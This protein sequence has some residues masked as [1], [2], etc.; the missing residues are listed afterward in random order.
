MM[1]C[2]LVSIHVH[3]CRPLLKLSLSADDEVNKFAS[4]EYQKCFS[5]HWCL[6]YL[7][8]TNGTKKIQGLGNFCSSQSLEILE[9]F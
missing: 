7:E 8:V 5:F 1:G 9:A 2:K 3:V 6:V 4:C